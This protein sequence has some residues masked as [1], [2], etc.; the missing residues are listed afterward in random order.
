MVPMLVLIPLQRQ[1]QQGQQQTGR[2]FSAVA[3]AELRAA[4]VGG[5]LTYCII[6]YATQSCCSMQTEALSSLKP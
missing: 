2:G 5:L 4:A 6:T 3:V 1:Q